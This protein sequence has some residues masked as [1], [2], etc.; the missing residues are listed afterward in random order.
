MIIG[1][2][3]PSL[4]VLLG[5]LIS[6]QYARNIEDRLAYVQ[7]ADDLKEHVLETRRNEKNFLYLKN[8]E[9]MANLHAALRILSES[10]R[11]ISP[12][13][14]D[15]IGP[16]D[17]FMLRE[18][19]E[20][21]PKIVDDL[22]VNYQEEGKAVEKVR[23]EGR[24]LEEYVAQEE[25]ASELTTSFILHL[26][27]QE[28]NYMLFRDRKSYQQFMAGLDMLKNITPFCNECSPYIRAV[29]GL[30]SIYEKSD[31]FINNLQVIGNSL[32]TVTEQIT[33]RERARIKS[34]LAETKQIMLVG[35]LTL[36]VLG[37]FFVYKT[38]GY[39]VAPILRLSRITRQIAEGDLSLR[40]PLRE[41]D[42]THSLAESFNT[43]LD[44]LQL[45]YQSLER[46]MELL[47]EKQAQL[48]ESEKRASLGLLVSGVAHELNNPLNNI[49]LIAERMFEERGEL[50]REEMRDF[51]NILTQCERA[52]NIVDNLLD[53]A[54]ARKSTV[55]ERQD[56][57][58]VVNESFTFVGN[59]LRINKI[60]LEKDIPEG[61][62]YIEG[63]RSKLEQILVSIFTNAIQAMKSHGTLTVSIKTDE[64]DSQ[65]VL[66]IGDT[67][68]GIREED[69]KNIFEP[70]FTTKPVG[71]GTGLGL[72]VCR[73]LVM[74][75]RGQIDAE[76]TL[77]QGTV[78]TIRFPLYREVA[79]RHGGGEP[80][81]DDSTG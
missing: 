15:E 12:E 16:S 41:H 54:R 40:A 59:Q 34:F 33:A 9:T 30:A 68:P 60:D 77:G 58:E 35:L 44:K 78:F 27:L 47:R 31:S 70:F 42:E 73:S 79:A 55:M 69:I 48:V 80:G 1:I 6:Y 67:G 17:I 20:F 29:G 7:I 14:A 39:I 3:I 28:K 72:S 45:T 10:V 75:H 49:S 61:P 81:S 4:F 26:R 2:T 64:E 13:T 8:A 51:N 62:V 76:S 57:V 25:H 36:C 5:G 18:S 23:A 52:K 21:Y 38:A 43:M 66:R 11:D 65:A 19:V 24:R 71:E 74:E 37:P 22:Y 63:N 32:E 50:T 56:I 46:S 53:F